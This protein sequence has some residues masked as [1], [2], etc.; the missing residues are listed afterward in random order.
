MK[1]SVLISILSLLYLQSPSNLSPGYTC[2]SSITPCDALYLNPKRTSNIKL[3]YFDKFKLKD[4]YA[5]SP[6]LSK[7]QKLSVASINTLVILL[8]EAQ[9][10]KLSSR[11]LSHGGR[12]TNKYKPFLLNRFNNDIKVPP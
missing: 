11:S 8:P 2:L 5:L 12:K 7:H 10:I 3:S 4:Q 9:T 1:R 6:L